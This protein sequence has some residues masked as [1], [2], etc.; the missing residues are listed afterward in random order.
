MAFSLIPE[1]EVTAHFSG[2]PSTVHLSPWPLSAHDLAQLCVLLFPSTTHMSV[3]TGCYFS[4]ITSKT[5]RVTP[6]SSLWNE[7]VKGK[8]LETVSGFAVA[9]VPPP[10]YCSQPQ[11]QLLLPP[12]RH[13]SRPTRTY[14]SLK[15]KGGLSVPSLGGL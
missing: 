10:L 12:S 4:C 15:C 11:L 13:C 6:D 1:D 14:T 7:S 8:L 2:T 3:Q 9:S 5:S